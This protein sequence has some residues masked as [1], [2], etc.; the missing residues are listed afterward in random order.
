MRAESFDLLWMGM[1]QQED[2]EIR[3][4][5]WEIEDAAVLNAARQGFYVFLA[6][7]YKLELTEAQIEALARQDLPVDDKYVGAGY[8]VVKEY[9]R[10]RHSGTRQELAVDYARVFLCA[11]MYEQLMAPPYES[12]YTSEDHLLMQDAR[13]EVL[14]RYRSEGLDLPADNT[15]PEDHL[16]FELQFMAKL[17]ERAQESLEAGVLDRYEELCAKQRVFFNEHLMN[18]VPRL[19][20]DV[21]AYAKTD[22]YRGIADITEGFLRFEGELFECG[23]QAA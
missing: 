7:V 17:I 9:I 2:K 12:V 20:A 22:F 4:K 19:C 14:D 1:K 21:R 13:D 3:M 23:E 10:H 6:S 8:A 18:W 5:Q 16:S 15:T 11:G